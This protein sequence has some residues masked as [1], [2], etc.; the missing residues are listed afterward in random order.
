M[1]EILLTRIISVISWYHLAFFVISLAMLGMTA[2]AIW[3]FVRPDDFEAEAVPRRLAQYALR[4]SLSTPLAVAL[5]L[6]MPLVPVRSFMDFCGLLAFGGALA[7]PFVFAGIV[8]TLALTRAGLSPAIAYGV[9]LVGAAVGCAL[10]IPLLGVFDAPSGVLVA[11]ALAAASAFAFARAAG[12]AGRSTSRWALVSLVLL[13][14]GAFGNRS[15]AEQSATFRPAWVK[16]MHE[17]TET[18]A[19]TRWNTYS[20]VT[21]DHTIEVPPT[22]WAPNRQMPEELRAPL[23]QRTIK[24]DGAAATMMAQDATQ[25][26][27][28]AYLDWDVTSFA[29]RLRPDGPAAVIGVGGGR[30]LLAARRGGHP[31][32]VGVE[33]NQL[34]VDLHEREMRDFSKL[35]DLEGVELVSDEA[36]SWFTRTD[37]RFSVIAMSLIDT[38]ASTGAGAYSL[39]ENGL[40]TVEAW[41]IFF[42]RLDDAG[43][44]T[45][46]RWWH[47]Q[48]PGETAR[49]IGLAMELLWSRGV[50]D[51]RRH[52]FVVQSDAVA[53][54]LVAKRPFTEAEI[55]ELQGEAI[56]LGF[57]MLATP[58]KTPSSELLAALWQQGD[59]ASFWSWARAQSLDLTPATDDRPFFF[60]MLRP[61]DWLRDKGEVD[62]MDVSFLGNLQ[63]TQT[64]V[65]ATLVSLLLTLITVVAPL[66]RRAEGLREL[67]TRMVVAACAYFAL[68]GLGFMFVE[69]ALLSRLNVLLGHPTTSLAVLLG[70]IIFFTGVGSLL[71]ERAPIQKRAFA[72]AY[73][74][75]P[76]LLVA[77]AAFASGPALAALSGAGLATR[78]LAGLSLVGI[79]AL[80]MGLG[81]PLGLRLV[82]RASPDPERPSLG[83]WL[84]G[85]NG[86]FGVCASGLA[87]GS[88]MVW[89]VPTTLVIGMV[90]Y[91]A[92]LP[93][94]RLLVAAGRQ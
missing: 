52:L 10:V 78:V 32:V 23:A 93:C 44:F 34:I 9:D 50:E 90:C 1:L 79:P 65:Y 4:F 81:F 62:A 75:I 91:L 18:L 37:R 74:I 39:S 14:V 82:G 12:D 6:A 55:D 20:R 21:V 61:G 8:L 41:G 68:I 83:P 43:L 57:N 38:W 89:G 3:V 87:L 29:H 49:M 94:T 63:A 27:R 66:R 5:A 17:A 64:L 45:V 11:S 28:H 47:P 7:V 72:L 48:S 77:A 46:S 73:P 69:I 71:S 59:R 51:P 36:R 2:G 92:L 42:D 58:R 86:A 67:P 24:I 40:Y 19:W 35:V 13:S 80:G 16:G 33:L 84:W 25:L 56:R 60:N 30:D 22:L 85:I 31:K 15:A 54:L 88:S 70:G 76:A 26:E 53:T